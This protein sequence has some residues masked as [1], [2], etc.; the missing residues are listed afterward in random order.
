MTAGDLE[1]A[2]GELAVT[3]GGLTISEPENAAGVVSESALTSGDQI[4]VRIAELSKVTQTVRTAPED[5][6]V[7]W[8]DC[9]VRP[10]ALGVKGR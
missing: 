9:E 4:T 8:I 5:R 1:N 6:R 7:V 3:L 10:S 2:A